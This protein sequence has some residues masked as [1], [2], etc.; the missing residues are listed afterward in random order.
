MS[1]GIFKNIPGGSI[2]TLLG[3]SPR[4]HKS[5]HH[6]PDDHHDFEGRNDADIP[7]GRD[8]ASVGNLFLSG[9]LV[10]SELQKSVKAGNRTAKTQTQTETDAWASKIIE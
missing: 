3:G 1:T 6:P 10:C 5:S 2:R 4:H 9:L 8:H 7:S